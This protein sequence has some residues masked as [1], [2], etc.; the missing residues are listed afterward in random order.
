[1]EREVRQRLALEEEVRQ[2]V[3]EEA[4]EPHFQPLMQLSENRLVGFEILARWHHPKLGSVPPDT[5]IPVVEKLGLIGNLTYSILRR[6]CKAARDWPQDITLALNVSPVHLFDPLLPVKTLAILSET[7]FPPRRLEMEITET[8]LVADI[9]GA[10]AVLTTLQ[11]LGI[12]ISLDDF[13]IGY[14]NLYS[15]RELQFDKIKIDRSF[16]QTMH[17]NSG[18]A[19]IVHSVIELAKSLGLPTIAEGIEHKD[20]LHQILR[21]GG[22]FGQGYYFGKAMPA[23]Q[24]EDLLRQHAPRRKAV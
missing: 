5:F 2:A 19:K 9:E 23:A 22:E 18:S 6:A 10:R 11:S 16:V 3:A 7:G 17:S 1:M 12:R 4:I 21:S 14:S 20:A 8:A 24:A 13:G 15:L